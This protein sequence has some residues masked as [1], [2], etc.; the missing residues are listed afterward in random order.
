MRRQLDPFEAPAFAIGQIFL[1]QTGEEL[2]NIRR[3]RF[4]T[5]IFDLR[6]VARRIRHHIVLK[7]D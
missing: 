6:P 7:R 2:E 4:M 3:G 5:E 1:L